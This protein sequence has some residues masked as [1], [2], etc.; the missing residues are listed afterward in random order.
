VKSGDYSSSR[1]WMCGI[2]HEAERIR[3][4]KPK[5]LVH[6]GKHRNLGSGPVAV[7]VNFTA[8]YKSLGVGR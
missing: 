7:V 2:G 6:L 1:I 5:E 4:E 3:R 8:H